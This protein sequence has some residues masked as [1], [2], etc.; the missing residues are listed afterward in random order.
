MDQSSK[1]PYATVLFKV[2]TERI[3]PELRRKVLTAIISQQ[4]L[5][6]GA[7]GNDEGDGCL[8]TV[9]VEA[10][11]GRKLAD[12]ECDEEF[13]AS[14]LGIPAQVVKDATDLWDDLGDKKSGQFLNRIREY[15]CVTGPDA[16]PHGR[17]YE[18]GY[19]VTREAPY[20]FQRLPEASSAASA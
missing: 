9:G 17:R 3:K 8:F 12:A 2:F 6:K 16:L 11:L 15:L 14:V 4:C 10:V 20:V 19:S 5:V 18:F 7:W 13:M 1:I